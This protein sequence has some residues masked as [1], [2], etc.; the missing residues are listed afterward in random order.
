[1]LI[2]P[3]LEVPL[4]PLT[5]RVDQI[6]IEQINSYLQ[7][8]IGYFYSCN[9]FVI[10]HDQVMVSSSSGGGRTDAWPDGFT[11][12]IYNTVI[13][14]PLYKGGDVIFKVVRRGAA[15]GTAVMRYYA[16]RLRN[17]AAFLALASAVSI[18][19][20]PGNTNTNTTTVTLTG[21]DIT[22]GDILRFDVERLGNDAGDTMVG[23]VINEAITV[24]FA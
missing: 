18:N 22:V 3:K 13:V 10:E 17:S 6:N 24:S 4:F 14:S 12:V 19:Y 2:L 8:L 20:T 11:S 23:D 16:Y 15:T 21:L 9:A 7:S 1:M 5:T